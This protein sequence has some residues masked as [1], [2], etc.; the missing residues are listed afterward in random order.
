MARTTARLPNGTRISD[1]VTLGVLTAT[2]SGDLID[3]V[4]AET[5]R[6][7]QRQRPARVVVYYVMALALYA[8]A[9][10]GEVLRCLL[11]GVRWLRLGGHRQVVGP[12]P[13][14]FLAEGDAEAEFR[15]RRQ[16]R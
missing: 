12:G 2:V 15:S 1:H 10:Y 8:Q 14:K 13:A 7:S 6:Q 4:L 11:E 16:P 3:A 5:G 9:S